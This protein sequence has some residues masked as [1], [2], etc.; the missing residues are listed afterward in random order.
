MR[1]LFSYEAD[2]QLREDL[3]QEVFLALLHSVG[4]VMAADNEKAYVFRI[5]HNVAVDH[6]AKAVKQRTDYLEPDRLNELQEA[7]QVGVAPSPAVQ[8]SQNQQREQLL[9]AVSKMSTPNRQVIALV[10]E[11]FSQ[12]EIA[13]ILQLRG[14]TVRVRINRA[15]T[16]LRRLLRPRGN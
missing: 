14:N 3:A 12:Q 1:T 10:L 9:R 5:V 11:D 7:Q 13:N 16:E 2:A 15:K 6:I 8:V 4:T